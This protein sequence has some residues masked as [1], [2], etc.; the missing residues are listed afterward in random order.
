MPELIPGD[1][2]TPKDG[3]YKGLVGNLVRVQML[4]DGPELQPIRQIA[5]VCYPKL[6]GRIGWH[7]MANLMPESDLD[8][9]VDNR[10]R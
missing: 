4:N 10:A 7:D 9:G 6:D 8:S 2:V 5:L 3:H 1:W